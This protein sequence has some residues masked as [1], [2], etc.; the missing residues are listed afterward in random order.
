MY[1]GHLL[2]CDVLPGGNDLIIK[3]WLVVFR[4]VIRDRS[5]VV[6]GAEYRPNSSQVRVLDSG[7][8]KTSADPLVLMN[9]SLKGVRKRRERYH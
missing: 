8:P 5:L 4:K 7:V 1:C 6:H 9:Q 2:R 3:T